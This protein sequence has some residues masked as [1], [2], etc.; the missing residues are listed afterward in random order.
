MPPHRK[1][2]ARLPE[3]GN[4]DSD[5]AR[6]VHLIISMIKWIW[7][8]RLSIK[9]SLPAVPELVDHV[10]IGHDDALGHSAQQPLSHRMYS[11]IGLIK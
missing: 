7:T 5:G 11:F 6:P 4:S 3:Q 10:I 8:S 9:S 2:D 1:V